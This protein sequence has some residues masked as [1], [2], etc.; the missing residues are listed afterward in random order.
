MRAW[1]RIINSMRSNTIHSV[2]SLLRLY[3]ALIVPIASYGS[4]VW[5]SQTLS[6]S[7]DPFQNWNKQQ[8]N[9]TSIKISKSILGVPK[10]TSNIGALSE[11]GIYPLSVTILTNIF[12]FYSRL[13][14]L[15][16]D[17]ILYSAYLEDLKLQASSWTTNIEN[18]LIHLFPNRNP[19]Q[20]T[21]LQFTKSLKERFQ[22]LYLISTDQL[23]SDDRHKLGCL[24]SMN[25]SY[26]LK[27]YLSAIKNRQHQAKNDHTEA[28]CQQTADRTG[29]IQWN[30]S[31]AKGLS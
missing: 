16:Q 20:I 7:S 8:C 30:T 14:T 19:Q 6:Q 15:D 2:D 26:G 28:E 13:F 10:H 21:S 11:L 25:E 5:G 3:S 9:F 1:F 24:G 23:Q 27:V 29:K 18:L 12:K 4:E 31:R 22:H 17:R